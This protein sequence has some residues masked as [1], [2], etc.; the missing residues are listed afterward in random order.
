[1]SDNWVDL[2][3]GLGSALAWPLFVF[4]LAWM[5][6]GEI[7]TLIS[8]IQEINLGALGVV[9]FVERQVANTKAKADIKWPSQDSDSTD[10]RILDIADAYPR[11][12]V[13]ESW[14]GIEKGLIDL[15]RSRQI[16]ITP[17]MRIS[18]ERI[19]WELLGREVIDEDMVAI[20]NDMQN[21]R[22]II[23]QELNISPS[24]DI[25]LKYATV[26]SQVGTALQKKICT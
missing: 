26:A 17:P 22:N 9:K 18:P 12:A 2:I 10:E 19:V 1:M 5:F 24:R 23:V 11:G 3:V 21:I 13:I 4:A 15:A 20:L 25:V 8:L 16:D 14:Y 6:R 7:R